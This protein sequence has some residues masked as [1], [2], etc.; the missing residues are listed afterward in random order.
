[1]IAF[2]GRNKIVIEHNVYFSGLIV[3]IIGHGLAYKI[4]DLWSKINKPVITRP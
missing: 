1:M 4:W 2:L 3:G